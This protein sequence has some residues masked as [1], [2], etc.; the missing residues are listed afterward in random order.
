MKNEIG[1]G[2]TA[3][4]YEKDG[5][6]I[7]VFNDGFHFSSI[8]REFKYAKLAYKNGCD[9][10]NVYDIGKIDGLD[11]IKYELLKG[12]T[13]EQ[14]LIEDS[15][16]VVEYGKSMAKIQTKLHDVKLEQ[17]D[18]EEFFIKRFGYIDEFD[19][20]K[21]NK[22]IKYTRSLDHN[23]SLCHGDFHPGN[24]MFNGDNPY[25]IDWMNGN[26]SNPLSD[27]C[28]TYIMLKSPF[29]YLSTPVEVQE[30]VKSIIN[31]LL[32]AYL[33]EYTKINSIDRAEIFKWILPIATLRLLEHIPYEK[34]WIL[35]LIE[36]EISKL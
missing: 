14:Q 3:S 2:R 22:I 23:I 27:V 26:S 16:K 31:I 32:E 15:S 7:K 25:I 35:G 33:D 30:E 4:V 20:E 29:A 10:P 28:R 19:Q 17:N 34:E 1:K 5:F 18:F 24:I 21:M 11:Y 13:M 36:E 8:E 6:A 9:V 12:Q